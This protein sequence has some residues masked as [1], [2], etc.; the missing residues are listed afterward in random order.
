MGCIKCEKEIPEG[1][2]F[3]PWC[4]KKQ[5]ATEQKKRQRANGEGSVHK[6]RGGW[7][8]QIT[9]GYKIINGRSQ[10][11]RRSKAGFKTKKEAIEY[12]PLLRSGPTSRQ[13][14][15]VRTLWE[16]YQAGEYKK[17][18][19]SRQEKYRIAWPRLS[20]IAD[21][22]IDLLTTADLRAVVDA[23][24]KTYYP[25][26][27]MRDLLS[28]LYQIAM[29][30]QFVPTNL[31]EFIILPDLQKKEQDAFT[32][33]EVTKFWNDYDSGH[34]WT[35][36]ILVMLYSGMMPG[37]LMDC[38]K[39]QIDLKA[40]T[41][42]GAGKKT[43]VRKE[44]PIVLANEIIP[45]L[46]TLMDHNKGEKLISINKDNFYK[47]YYET[48]ERVG[49]RKLPPYTCR[50]TTATVLAN[51]SVPPSQVQAIMRHASITTTQHYIHN[52]PDDLL[53]AV[54]VMSTAHKK[55]TSCTQLLSD[56]GNQNISDSEMNES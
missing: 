43:E 55:E 34:T 47:V 18:S 53:N 42:T 40:R 8:A 35:G 22:R 45:V 25:A 28:L 46:E 16:E 14:P 20:S 27:D 37:E 15:T 50:H 10:A 33:E 5:S 48:L 7:R 51:A 56:S 1:A 3:C 30:N 36:Y 6:Y 24:A 32:S 41:V 44:K 9:I 12:L 11:I 2:L 23:N 54:D 52:R 13:I 4:G 31:A 19:A 29:A 39:S 26:R 21:A 38:K 17:L 49:C